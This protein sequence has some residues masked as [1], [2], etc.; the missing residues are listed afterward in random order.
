LTSA[1]DAELNAMLDSLG[2]VGAVLTDRK[3]VAFGTSTRR[4]PAEGRLDHDVIGSNT[5]SR[6]GNRLPGCSHTVQANAVDTKIV[7]P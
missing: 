4:R 2:D 7:K 3:P 6:C 1:R 5:E